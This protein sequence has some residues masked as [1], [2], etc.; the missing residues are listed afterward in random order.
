[1]LTPQSTLPDAARQVG[2][3]TGEKARR[4]RPLAPPLEWQ[5]GARAA[6]VTGTGQDAHLAAPQCLA[7][8]AKE[9]LKMLWGHTLLRVP[10][11]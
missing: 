8:L 5:P 4:P 9:L 10:G 6:V 3:G 11:A 1:M 2:T 7:Q